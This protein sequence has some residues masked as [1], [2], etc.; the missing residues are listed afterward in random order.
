MWRATLRSLLSHKLRMALSGLA[1]VLGVAFVSGTM[2]F[3]DTLS[4]TFN[5]LFTATA[6]DVNIE[7]AAAFEVGLTGTGGSSATESVP[8]SVVDRVEDVEG[9]AEVGGYVQAE[10]VYVLGKDGKVLDTGGAPGLGISWE[11]R[12]SLSATTLV[13]GE[14]PSGP[15]EIALDTGAVEETGYEIGDRVVVLTTGPRVEAE[16]VGVFR[17][18]DSGGLAGASLTAFDTATA[19]ELLGEEGQYTGVSVAAEDGVSDEALRDGIAGV[20]GDDY[21]VKTQEE[22]AEDLSSSFADSLQFISVFLLAF[23]G[24]AL[25]VGTFIILNTFSMLVAQRTREL[26]MLRALGA[27]RRQ[28]TRSVLLEALVLGLLGSTA[29]LL[30]G[31]GIASALRALFGRFG[32]TLDGG[33]VFAAD[34]VVWSYAVGVLV[35]LLAAYFPARRAS[36]TAPMAALREDATPPEKSLRRRT[37]IG[38]VLLALA[39]AALV[40]AARTEDGSTAASFVGLGSLALLVGAIAL[41]PV[42]ARPFLAVVGSLLPRLWGST[43][44]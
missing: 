23:A 19:Q 40:Q 28:V 44:W 38:S 22:Q 24:I 30:G 15:G 21:D 25:F 12:E 13:D 39:V 35:T 9:V 18:G 34:T 8:Q 4:K 27:S 17:F 11:S 7:P 20:L 26:A 16:L 10:G 2:I 33:L 31:F 42:L 14:A 29:G 5:D 37:V 41:S 6:A 36:R 1:I 43:R 3:T 32:L